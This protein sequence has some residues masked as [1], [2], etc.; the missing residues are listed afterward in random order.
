MNLPFILFKFREELREI[1][2]PVQQL[3][4]ILQIVY[5]ARITENDLVR[6]GNLTQSYLE[7]YKNVFNTHL[8]PKHHLLL[9]YARVMRAMGPVMLF[10]VMRMESKHQFFKRV[11]QKTKNFINLKHTMAQQHQESLSLVGSAYVDQIE[12]SKKS[13]PFEFCADFDLNEN[14]LMQMFTRT[15]LEEATIVNSLQ[16]NNIKYKPDFLIKFDNV[17]CEIKKI[18]VCKNRF[19]L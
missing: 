11:S 2:T 19:G 10:S 17:I 15:M 4:Q 7:S 12:M 14:I 13:T 9:H 5:S 18:I 3:Q 1:W 6:F 16:I 8:R